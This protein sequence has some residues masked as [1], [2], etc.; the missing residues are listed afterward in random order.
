MKTKFPLGTII[1]E[2]I[3]EVAAQITINGKVPEYSPYVAIETLDK[4]LYYIMDKDL[5][6]FAVN[7]LKALGKYQT[8][9]K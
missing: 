8:Q 2:Q 3:V 4:R 9:S 7:I 5:E 1:N 6:R